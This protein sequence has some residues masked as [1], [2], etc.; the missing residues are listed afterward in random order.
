MIK[1]NNSLS[2][3]INDDSLKK[4]LF[5]GIENLTNWKQEQKNL[6]TIISNH[7]TYYKGCSSNEVIAE[8]RNSS[9]KL[10]KFVTFF[11][12]LVKD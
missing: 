4:L 5:K 8:D 12:Q 2:Q 7:S 6:L 1:E 11:K 10:T 9:S 3:V